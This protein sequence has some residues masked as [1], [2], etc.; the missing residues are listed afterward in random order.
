MWKKLE[1]LSIRRF[2][3]ISPQQ[4]HT[5]QSEIGIGQATIVPYRYQ[6]VEYLPWQ[7]L[8]NFE[9]QSQKPQQITT[10]D[11]LTIPFDNITWCLLLGFSVF[12]FAFL[13]FI[14][15]LWIR[16]TGEVPPTGWMFQ[17]NIANIRTSEY[18]QILQSFIR[19]NNPSL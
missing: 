18:L 6:L 9:V 14:Q 10:Y 3:I 2:K 19:I 7:F 13:I 5:K 4:V 1:I 12:V 8:Y 17:G 16:T 11:A 15:K